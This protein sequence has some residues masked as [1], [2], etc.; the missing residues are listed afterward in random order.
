MRCY[1]P[2]QTPSLVTN[3]RGNILIRIYRTTLL[4]RDSV[5]VWPRPLM[6]SRTLESAWNHE[7]SDGWK[8]S[9]GHLLCSL[10]SFMTRHV[11]IASLVCLRSLKISFLYSKI[12]K[13]EPGTR[14][15]YSGWLQTGR[16]RGRSSSPGR[17]K[18]FLFSTSFR[19]A[20][21]PTQPPSQWVPAVKR[22]GR[23]PD[24]SP[25]TRAD[26]KKT[27]PYTSTPPYAFMA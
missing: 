7:F 21:E 15:R 9:T 24:H 20:R 5:E 13:K 10:S 2:I 22:Q 8:N 1:S 19:P 27:W 25:P 26:V 14:S 16:P 4:Q 6:T 17:V 3:T 11:Y 18:N 12:H 23:E